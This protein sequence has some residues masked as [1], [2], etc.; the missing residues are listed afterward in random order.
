MLNL[1][2]FAE[3]LDSLLF[4]AK[5][6]PP[7]FAKIL[8]CGRATI[9]RYLSGTKMPTVEMTVRMADYFQVSTDFLLGLE[10]E[11]HAKFF[12][13]Y[14]PFRERLPQLCKK[15]NIT[16]YQLQKKTKI[17]ESAIYNWQAGRT[18]PTIES[19]VR[20]AE[21]LQCTVDCVLGRETEF[22]L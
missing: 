9:N 20:I 15:F 18:N 12:C 4:D 19:V 13:P 5:L 6:N 1:S 14:I 21:A 10:E 16:K 7:A 11:N 22:H 3:R 17:P 8:G 2:I